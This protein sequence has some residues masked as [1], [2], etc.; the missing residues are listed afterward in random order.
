MA[1]GKKFTQ[2]SSSYSTPTIHHA[3][4]LEDAPT[5]QMDYARTKNVYHH[6]LILGQPSQLKGFE[7]Q[8]GYS[9][10]NL[11][12]GSFP[13]KFLPVAVATQIILRVITLSQISDWPFPILN[14]IS[15]NALVLR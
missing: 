15:S 7:K 4:A 8:R 2:S 5:G 12:G 1:F 13:I 14:I 10:P 6:Q 9:V 11:G 3:A